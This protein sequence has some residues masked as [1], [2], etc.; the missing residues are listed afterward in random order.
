METMGP[1]GEV[2]TAGT[3]ARGL[4]RR[5][6]LPHLLEKKL[7]FRQKK[8]KNSSKIYIMKVLMKPFLCPGLDKEH[9]LRDTS[10]C[11]AFIHSKGNAYFL[12]SICWGHTRD[13]DQAEADT[14]CRATSR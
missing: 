13:G 3:P 4:T 9:S 11:N 14:L 1:G 2:V 5:C 10:S 8:K 7:A 6:P 12:G